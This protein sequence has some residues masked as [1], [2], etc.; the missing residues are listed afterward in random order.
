MYPSSS[1]THGSDSFFVSAMVCFPDRTLLSVIPIS[2]CSLGFSS[3]WHFKNRMF[4]ETPRTCKLCVYSLPPLLNSK[5]PSPPAAT[6]Q[7]FA[8]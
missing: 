6:P 7:Y 1:L 3:S 8:L 4:K 5:L 2:A